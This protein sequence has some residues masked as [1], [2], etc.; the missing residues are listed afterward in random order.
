MR[1]RLDHIYVQQREEIMIT[2]YDE[3]QSQLAFPYFDTASRE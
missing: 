3:L 2:T 1:K